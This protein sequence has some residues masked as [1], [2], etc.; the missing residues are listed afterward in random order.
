MLEF[1]GGRPIRLT[2]DRENL[3]LMSPSPKPK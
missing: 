3:E 2:Y 1:V